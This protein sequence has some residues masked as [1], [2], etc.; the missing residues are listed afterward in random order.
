[1]EAALFFEG[2]LL[3]LAYLNFTA[4]FWKKKQ[5]VKMK[6]TALKTKKKF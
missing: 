6:Q 5:N 4:S 2:T 3:S 1:M